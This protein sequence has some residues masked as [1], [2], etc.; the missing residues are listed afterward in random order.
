MP[1]GLGTTGL[2]SLLCLILTTSPACGEEER[3]DG[4]G[5]PGISNEKSVGP[6][7]GTPLPGHGGPTGSGIRYV[8]DAIP[9]IDYPPFEGEYYEDL[10]P[11]TLD[12]AER[13]ALAVHGMTATLD[14]LADYE[15]YNWMGKLKDGRLILEHS[16]N[17]YN[18]LQP[19]WIE[20]LPLLRTVSGSDENLQI[21]K[22]MMEILFH[23]LNPDTG[24]YNIPVEGAPWDDHKTD[25]DTKQVYN[26]WPAGRALA[27]LCCWHSRQPNEVFR[28][29]IEHMVDGFTELAVYEEG[30]CYFFERMRNDPEPSP[31]KPHP[32]TT[33]M[34]MSTIMSGLAAAWHT[35]G[36]APAR[37][38]G[39]KLARFLVHH[40]GMFESD[41][42]FT[43]VH[44]HGTTHML[45]GLLDLGLSTGNQELVDF[46]NRA[47]AFGRAQGI[48]QMGWYPELY[49]TRHAGVEPC[50]VGDMAALAVKL[51]AAGV[52]DWWEDAEY[53]VRN[54]LQSSQI[55]ESRWLERLASQ[56][57]GGGPLRPPYENDVDVAKRMMG[58]FSGLVAANGFFQP[59]STGCCTGNAA[60]ALYH[61]WRQALTVKH[62]ELRVNLLLNRASRKADIYSYLPYNGRVDVKLKKRQHLSVRLP[63][64]ARDKNSIRCTVDGKERKC[65]V[66]NHY[67]EVGWVDADSI[68]SVRFPIWRRT[69]SKTIQVRLAGDGRPLPDSHRDKTYSLDI[70]GFDIVDIWPRTQVDSTTAMATNWMFGREDEIQPE[71]WIFHPFYTRSDYRAD[72]PRFVRRRRFTPHDEMKW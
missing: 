55:T 23:M 63:S 35:T 58:T 52:G 6:K 42:S 68:V 12:L 69:V 21:D 29:A 15:A 44:F 10:V 25:E 11:D 28:K 34:T 57:S 59:V 36:Y 64:W 1:I 61:V 37:E 30:S 14:P 47:Y 17:D 50:Q 43:P 31:V 19:K 56:H 71:N 5:Y 41:G 24:L 70:K 16:Y 67:L 65:L 53:A 18:G 62:D 51:S 4:R 9:T 8:R 49:P 38:L 33:S 54:Q 72:E 7:T 39:E 26:S 20:T 45:L 60:R 66:R 13:C 32:F 22:R 46:V 3:K 40:S 2:M 27:A 48:P